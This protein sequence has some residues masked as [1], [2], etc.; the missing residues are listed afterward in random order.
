SKA[1]IKEGD[2]ILKVD[3]REVNEPN[4]L[5]SYVASKS[6]GTE[7]HLTLFRD[8]KEIDKSV[9][10]KARD[11]D[12]KIEPIANKSNDEDSGTSKSVTANF[13]NLGF[14]VKNLSSKE[15]DAYKVDNGVVISEVKP[16]S[17]AEDQ[18]LFQGLVITEADKKKVK[19][20]K[21]LQEILND[22]KGSAVLLKVQDPQGNSRFVGIEIPE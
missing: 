10:L 2:V 9:T 11:E 20:I 19:D 14:S 18:R 16:F 12:T 5:Q 15:K 6:A 7:V 17:R 4:T 3:G 8:G 21:Q 13:S 1:G 22:K